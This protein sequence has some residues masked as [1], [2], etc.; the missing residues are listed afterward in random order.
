MQRTRTL[1][2]R[3]TTET[4][5]RRSTLPDQATMSVDVGREV[6]ISWLKSLC[7]AVDYQTGDFQSEEGGGGDK[8]MYLHRR[9]NQHGGWRVTYQDL[10]SPF[11]RKLQSPLT[12]QSQPPITPF[13]FR[14]ST[15]GMISALLLSHCS[16]ISSCASAGTARR[17]NLLSEHVPHRKSASFL[18][19]GMF[20]VSVRPMHIILAACVQRITARGPVGSASR[21][22]M[23]QCRA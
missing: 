10:S 19:S 20:P 22:L 23:M 2:V 16:T 12:S 3:L 8:S 9:R 14:Q 6:T 5:R 7:R 15:V 4:H 18:S 17:T 11:V 1:A 21:A 13:P